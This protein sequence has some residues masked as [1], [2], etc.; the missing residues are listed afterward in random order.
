MF[1]EFQYI[2]ERLGVSTVGNY[3]IDVGESPLL[4]MER[5]GGNVGEF[6]HLT[7]NRIHR[8]V[9]PRSDMSC[10]LVLRGPRQK[11]Y[12]S[13]FSKSQKY[14]PTGNTMFSPASVAEKLSMVAEEIK[15]R[16]GGKA[17]D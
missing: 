1:R 2:P 8:V 14:D 10:T 12:A 17:V 13:V 4:E 3:Y 11:N 7:Y 9:L 6:Y 5:S 15:K 16:T